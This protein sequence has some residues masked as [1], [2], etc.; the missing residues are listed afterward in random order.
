VFGNSLKPRG[1]PPCRTPSSSDSIAA[2][3][4]RSSTHLFESLD[5][6]RVITDAWLDTYNTERRH[7]RLGR[8][9]PLIFLPRPDVSVV[10]SFAVST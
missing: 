6:V 5:Q 1:A 4:K 2:V 3:A 10:S 9:P 8:V 7:D